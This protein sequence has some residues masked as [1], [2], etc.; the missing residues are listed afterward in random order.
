MKTWVDFGNIN[1]SLSGFFHEST[2]HMS[3]SSK[4]SGFFGFL[5]KTDSNGE[6]APIDA[7][8]FFD[9]LG[10]SEEPE[11]VGDDTKS[12]ETSDTTSDGIRASSGGS[13][14]VEKFKKMFMGTPS[15]SYSR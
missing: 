12:S 5:T 8:S 15:K 10:G 13:S 7:E 1:T 3:R 11:L 4:R 6:N 14:A 9:S 2:A